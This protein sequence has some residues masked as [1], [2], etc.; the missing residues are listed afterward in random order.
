M[1]INSFLVPACVSAETVARL[2]ARIAA[3]PK[4]KY[5][6]MTLNLSLIVAYG[7]QS[8][9]ITALTSSKVLIHESVSEP[10]P[11]SSETV[12]TGAFLIVKCWLVTYRIGIEFRAPNPNTDAVSFLQKHLQ[13]WTKIAPIARSFLTIDEI[14]FERWT[15]GRP[16]S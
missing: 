6:L 4:V 13:K 3:A 14:L 11:L 2:A 9:C 16:T 12:N 10:C 15:D 5:F 8:R 7:R 1:V